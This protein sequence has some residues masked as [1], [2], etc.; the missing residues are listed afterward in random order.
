ME[1]LS[2]GMQ[3]E[4][5]IARPIADYQSSAVAADEDAIAHMNEG[6]VIMVKTQH[7]VCSG[8]G[9]LVFSWECG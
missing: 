5:E 8:K 4:R 2:N 6:N 7:K 3:P 9:L 1:L